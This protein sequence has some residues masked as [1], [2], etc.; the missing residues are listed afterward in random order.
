MLGVEV[1]LSSKG[2]GVGKSVKVKAGWGLGASCLLLE[3]F[4]KWF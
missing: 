1:G 3:I 4:R 2:E